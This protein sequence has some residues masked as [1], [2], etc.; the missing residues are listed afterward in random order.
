MLPDS[1]SLED[2]RAAA[3]S[4]ARMAWVRCPALLRQPYALVAGL[5][6]LGDSV[7]QLDSSLPADFFAFRRFC[8]AEGRDGEM[9]RHDAP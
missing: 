3:S 5:C 7:Y 9:L 1:A 4:L 2:T 6:D 8:L